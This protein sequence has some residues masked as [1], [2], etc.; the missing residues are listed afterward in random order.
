[1]SFLLY[2][3]DQP[4]LVNY[5]GA[6]NALEAGLRMQPGPVTMSELLSPGFKPL[7]GPKPRALYLKQ[8]SRQWLIMI[9]VTDRN[10]NWPKLSCICNGMS[11]EETQ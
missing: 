11:L 5:G 3:A 4:L 1:M 2:V 9:L 8:M 6:S 10:G 7:S